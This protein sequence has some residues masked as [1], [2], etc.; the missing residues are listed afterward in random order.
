[1]KLLL[2]KLNHLGDT[3]LLTPTVRALRQKYP[4]A[5]IDVVVRPGCEAV[6][7]GN[8]DISN[9][10]TSDAAL[11][12]VFGQ[13]YDYAFDLSNSDRAKVLIALSAAKV[14]AINEW[15]AELGWKRA[16]FNR[17][18]HFEW[19]REHQVLRDYRAVADV[20]DIPEV[21]PLVLDTSVEVPA[22]AGPYAVVHPVSRW[23]FKEWLPDRWALLADRLAR[24]HG[25]QVVF[26]SGPAPRERAYVQ[27]I[28]NLSSQRHGTTGGEL[29]LR[30]LGRLIRG[31]RL[32]AGVDTVAMHIAAAVQAPVVAL[33]GPSSEWSWR[34]WQT[35]HQLV[36]GPCSC[37][38]TREFV[39]DKSAVYPCMAAITAESV[40]DAAAR[41]LG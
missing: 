26:S 29:T 22:P 41:L 4:D 40:S 38:V 11:G 7:E 25:L 28:L 23:A 15:H 9:V 6:L 30:Q 32:F 20:I 37:K 8:H 39:C 10:V 24:Q 3:L 18:T 1:M 27:S 21:G 16:V 19:A 17:F 35:R 14:R 12:R 33:F 5:R 36:L 13:R 31:A 34:P 2:A